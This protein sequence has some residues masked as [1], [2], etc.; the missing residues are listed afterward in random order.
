MKKTHHKTLKAIVYAIVVFAWLPAKATVSGMPFF[1]EQA[2]LSTI[3]QTSA[4]NAQQFIDTSKEEIDAYFE[5]VIE[6]KNDRIKFYRTNDKILDDLT[7]IVN[8]YLYQ[9]CASLDLSFDGFS[10]TVNNAVYQLDKVD[11][12]NGLK[13]TPEQLETRLLSL[14]SKLAQEL[15]T[16]M[17]PFLKKE[18]ASNEDRPKKYQKL[19]PIETEPLYS[20]N[21]DDPVV[22]NPFNNS[23]LFEDVELGER[24]VDLLESNNQL[25]ELLSAQI[26]TLQSEMIEMKK[27]GILYQREFSDIHKRIDGLEEAIQGIRESNATTSTG[28]TLKPV[29]AKGVSTVYFKKNSLSITSLY[30]DVLNDVYNQLQRQSKLRI[31]VTGYADKSG[32]AALNNKI[33]RQRALAVSQYLQRKGITKNRILLNYLGDANSTKEGPSD[34]KV[35]IEWLTE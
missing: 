17:D 25:I 22:L 3:E 18:T 2:L 8:F 27:E 29:G 14:K 5:R 30:H 21:E 32:N 24:I 15:K 33:S 20:L 16:F 13:V 35:E 34:R 10:P 12:T 19:E 11:I 1:F 7:D 26:M 28:P 9:H 4:A 23:P 31:I 6:V